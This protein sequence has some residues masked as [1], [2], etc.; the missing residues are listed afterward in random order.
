MTD[1]LVAQQAAHARLHA[2][3]TLVEHRLDIHLHQEV[4]PAAQVQTQK[5]RIRMQALQPLRSIRQQVE[6]DDIGRI[7]RIGIQ[8]FFQ[9]SL[10]LELDIGT[11]EARTNGRLC[12][13]VIEC[14]AFRRQ[15]ALLQYLLDPLG[16]RVFYLD[17]RFG[18]ADLHS[19]RFAKEIRQ[20]IQHAEQQGDNDY[21]VLP[22]RIAIHI[23]SALFRDIRRRPMD[24]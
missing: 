15:I 7:G 13:A 12:R 17:G 24:I 16:D 3:Q 22:E 8:F 4:H 14:D 6:G 20:R 19:R 23:D 21:Y 18:A 2:L 11:A 10:G 5:H 9:Q 1:I